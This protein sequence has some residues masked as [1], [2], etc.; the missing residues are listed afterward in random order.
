MGRPS[1]V[2]ITAKLVIYAD[3][4]KWDYTLTYIYNVHVHNFQ[5]SVADII[6]KEKID[7]Y[8]AVHNYYV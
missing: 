3:M 5:V 1:I 2:K 8:C 4:H 6:F 7:F